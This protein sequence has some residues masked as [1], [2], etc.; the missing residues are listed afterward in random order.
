MNQKE[1]G[2]HEQ[3]IDELDTIWE[4]ISQREDAG[5]EA[6]RQIK[7]L[8]KEVEDLKARLASCEAELDHG[9]Q[10]VNKR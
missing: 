2:E 9:Q 4:V 8:K 10:E 6:C 7:N 5:T 3:R 1:A